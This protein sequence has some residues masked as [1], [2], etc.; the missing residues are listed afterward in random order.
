MCQPS[1]CA[2]VLL[3]IVLSGISA[4]PFHAYRIRS[5]AISVTLDS[6]GQVASVSLGPKKIRRRVLGWTEIQG[7]NIEGHVTAN[8]L[9]NGGWQFEKKLLCQVHGSH[10]LLLEERFSPTQESIRWQI[11][12]VERGPSSSPWSTPIE[13][14]LKWLDVRQAKFWTTWG[15]DSPETSGAN[16]GL[17]ISE[18]TPRKE[19]L[20]DY[21]E[22]RWKDPLVPRGFRNIELWYGGHPYLE[23]GF[24]IP[25][26]TVL[27]K[28]SDI[29]MS[30]ALSPRDTVI[31]L[32]LTTM[33]DGLI[34]FSRFY[35]R[36]GGREPVRFSMDLIGHAADWRP[37]LGWMVRNYPNYFKPRGDQVRKLYGLGTYSGYQGP[38]DQEKLHKMDFKVNWNAHWGFPYQGMFLPPLKKGAPEAWTYRGRQNSARMK[39]DYC[40]SMRKMGFYVL[41]Y[42]NV[43]EFG[44]SSVWNFTPTPVA[45]DTPDLWKSPKE[46]LYTKIADGI[47]YFSDGKPI[48]AWAGIE[49][50]PGGKDYQNNLL[51]QAKAIRDDLPACSGIAIDEMYDL[52]RF[53][54]RADDG[55]TWINGH[56]V[57]ALTISWKELMAKLEPMMMQKDKP[58]FGNTLLK[59]LDL[60]NHLDGIFAEQGDQ[61]NEMNLDAF[62]SVLKPDIEWVTSKSRLRVHPN[63]FLQSY[64][65]MG[66]FPEAPYPGGNHS[67]RPAPWVDKFYLDYGPLFKAIDQRRWVFVPHVLEV[68]ND[69]AKANI[70]KV[71]GGYAIA[72]CFGGKAPSAAI[73][74]KG[75][76]NL[77]TANYKF[78]NPGDQEWTNLKPSL[79]ENQADVQVP[80]KRGCA[81][82]RIETRGGKS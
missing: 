34:T 57:R 14:H 61:G 30:L 42:F 80:L 52:A 45:P 69:T 11:Q 26:A 25:I 81:M 35:N 7:C 49:M 66:T 22:P 17:I 75:L 39:N 31:D 21:F 64:L 24:S 8:K 23:G 68:E 53:N 4:Y 76:S 37:A 15:D 56:A 55:V 3:F 44:D 20:D 73:T 47:V 5:R 32:R 1:R 12:L 33:P 29:G 16:A 51:E 59:R 67:I 48:R 50:D 72:I 9:D 40:E 43:T 54:H 6:K 58:V 10:E 36:L 70:F 63:R 71:P 79:R 13:T 27:E 65:F 41:S 19:T 28:D 74:V 46:F 60:M 18:R 78:I 38:L 2:C 77:E 62:L 82:V